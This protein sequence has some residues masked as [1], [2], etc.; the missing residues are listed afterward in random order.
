[1]TLAE[2]QKQNGGSSE[3]GSQ[4][5]SLHEPSDKTHFIAGKQKM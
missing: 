3:A 1:V 5:S 4:I 2:S